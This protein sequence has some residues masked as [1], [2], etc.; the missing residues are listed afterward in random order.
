MILPTKQQ[1]TTNE[2]KKITA[3]LASLIL[4]QSQHSPPETKEEQTR[5]KTT[6]CNQR[7]Q[8]EAKAAEELKERMPDRKR[9]AMT[10]S[11]EKGAS[12]W[13]ST[14]PMADHGF[15]LHKGAFRH[16]LCLHYGWSQRL[17]VEHAI[18]CSRGGFP[19]IWH[20][21]IRDVTTVPM[22]EVCH[23]VGI[24]PSLLAV[25][26]EQLRHKSANREDGAL[27]DIVAENFWG[28]DKQ[29]TFFDMLHGSFTEYTR[30]PH[31]ISSESVGF[32]K[33]SCDVYRICVSSRKASR[34]LQNSRTFFY[35]VHTQYS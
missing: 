27:L 6:A 32:R 29:H 2:V 11:V 26:E 5:A 31:R 10:V 25:K 12:R 24:E 28:R 1:L 22:N 16:T 35:V 30:N 9:R 23:G 20:N 21:E 18:S 13:L 17:T 8:Q 34:I 14:L 4:M 3:P 19:S 33:V 15:A 7:R